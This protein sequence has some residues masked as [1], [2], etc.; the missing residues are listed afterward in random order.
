VNRRAV[1]L[2][3]IAVPLLARSAAA[4]QRCDADPALVE[5]RGP[6]APES[7]LTALGLVDANARFTYLHGLLDDDARHARTWTVAWGIIGVGLIAGNA[8]LAA[9]TSDDVLRVDS[10]IA[11]AKSLFIPAVLVVQPIR[12]MRDAEKVDR[13]ADEFALPGRQGQVASCVPL[14]R[15]EELL[16]DAAEDE[17]LAT[18]WVAQIV[19]IGGNVAVGAVQAFGLGHWGGAAVGTF[20]GIAVGEVQILTH[21][22]GALDALEPYSNGHLGNRPTPLAWSVAPFA[23]PPVAPFGAP[24]AAAPAWGAALR[25]TF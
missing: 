18:R 2:L 24:L 4:Q 19:V 7:P 13:V 1:V 17:A 20:G 9:V 15:A 22:T 8:A 16:V 11:A 10:I 14:R 21:P 6:G 3:S 23:P 12:A 5:P 25:A